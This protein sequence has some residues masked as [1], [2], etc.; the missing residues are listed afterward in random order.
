MEVILSECPIEI[1]ISKLTVKIESPP[2]SLDLLRAIAK[3]SIASEALK[4]AIE[5]QS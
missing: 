2:V 4:S 3:L 1:H 5:S